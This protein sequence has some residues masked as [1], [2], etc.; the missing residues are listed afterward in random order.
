MIMSS[1]NRVTLIGN[2]GRD[3]ELKHLPNGDTVVS[4]SLATTY[5]KKQGDEWVDDTQWHRVVFYKRL[6]DMVGERVGKGT[7]IFVEG[8]IQYRSFE[9]D[10][11]KQTVTEIIGNDLQILAGKLNKKPAED[12]E[13]PF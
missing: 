6:A 9:K 2:V 3:P 4:I 10:G 13:I 11:A 1:V 8:R 5:K 7:M 12:E